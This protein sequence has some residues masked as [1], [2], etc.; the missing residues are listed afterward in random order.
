MKMNTI[1]SRLPA[2]L[3]KQSQ[4]CAA[5][6]FWGTTPKRSQKVHLK[7]FVQGSKLTKLY[8]CLSV[9]STL[10]LVWNNIANSRNILPSYTIHSYP[11]W[12]WSAY[13]QSQY[14]WT[15]Y[16]SS[17]GRIQ[18]KYLHNCHEVSDTLNLKERGQYFGSI[19]SL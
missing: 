11:L 7:I 3:L 16:F 10:I 4:F 1:F 15:I 2:H 14:V 17:R 18:S 9:S 19:L 13:T 6:K 5:N 8:I 12:R